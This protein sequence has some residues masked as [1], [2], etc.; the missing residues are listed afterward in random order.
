MA[1]Y[2]TVKIENGKELFD[3]NAPTFGKLIGGIGLIDKEKAIA[4]KIV[5]EVKKVLKKNR[6][7]ATVTYKTD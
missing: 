7:K 2:I 5:S 1:I 4:K 6:V 3:K